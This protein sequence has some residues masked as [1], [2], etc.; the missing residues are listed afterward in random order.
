MNKLA[1]RKESK[2][3]KKWVKKKRQH[4]FAV[5]AKVLPVG[6]PMF[7]GNITIYLL[8]LLERRSLGLCFQLASRNAAPCSPKVQGRRQLHK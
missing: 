7:P 3:E 4:L 2:T 5:P 6:G 1:L 8:F